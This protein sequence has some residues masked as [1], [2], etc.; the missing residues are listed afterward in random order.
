MNKTVIINMLKHLTVTLLILFS[1]KT[2]AQNTPQLVIPTLDRFSID[3]LNFIPAKKYLV[4]NGSDNNLKFWQLSDGR[5]VK[6]LEVEEVLKPVCTAVAPDG[7][8]MAFVAGFNIAWVNVD[9]FTVK[10]SEDMPQADGEAG[11]SYTTAVFSKDGKTLFVGGG[12]YNQII[13]WK[14]AVGSTK[15]VRLGSSEITAQD[16]DP[17]DGSG[18]DAVKGI[19]F[20]SLSTD[21]KMLLA[22]A[23]SRDVTVFSTETGK[24]KRI[25]EADGNCHSFLAGGGFVGSLRDGKNQASIVKMYSAEGKTL[26]NFKTTFYVLSIIPFPKSNNCILMGSSQYVVLDADSKKLGNI[27]K[28]PSKGIRTMKIDPDER[29]LAYGGAFDEHTSLAILDLKTQQTKFKLGESVFQ[30]EHIY[31][32]L[33]ASW[34]LLAKSGGG[35]LKTVKVQDGGLAVRNLPEY[36]SITS[37][38]LSPNGTQGVFGGYSNEAQFFNMQD[39]TPQ[40]K[41]I[42]G[43]DKLK[44]GFVMSNDGSLTAALTEQ[45]AIIFNTNTK[46]QLI[47]LLN[48]TDSEYNNEIF[49]GAFSPDNKRFVGTWGG[50]NAK[51]GVKCWDVATGKMIWNM[52]KVEYSHYRFSADG[53][54]IFCFNTSYKERA[55]VWIDAGNGQVVRSVKLDIPY[56]NNIPL[57]IAN[58]NSTI[59][60]KKALK[61]YDTKTGKMLGEYKPSGVINGSE[62]LAGGQ[63]GLVSYMSSADEDNLQVKLVLYDFLNQKVLANI[64]LYDETDDW[65]IITPD[66]HYDATQGAMKKMY[67]AQGT[68]LIGLEELSERFYTPKLLSQLLKGYTPSSEDNIKKLKRPPMVK[69]IYEP[70][71]KVKE[72]LLEDQVLETVSDKTPIQVTIEATAPDD[73]VEEMRLYHNGKLIANNTRNL[74]VDDDKK[75]SDK[76]VF[77]IELVEGENFLK[78]VALNSQR[79]ESKADAIKITYKPLNTGAVKPTNANDITLH[80]IVIGINKYKNPKYNLNYANADATAFKE[81]IEK[82]SSSIFSNTNVVLI[83]DDKA[84]KEGIS[85]ELDKVKLLASPKDVF[86]F[87]YAGHGVLNEKKEFFLVPHDVTQL[88]GQDEALAQKGLSANQLQQ[89]SKDIKAQKQLFILDACQSAGALDQIVA[90]RGAAEEKAIAQLARATGTHWLTA[91]GSEQF[92][93]EFAQLGHGTF[94]YVLLEALSGK[95]D[96]GGDKKVTVKELDAYLQEVVPEVTAKYKGTPQYPASYG[97][98]NDFPIG[99]VKQ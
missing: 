22:S 39:K 26:A 43:I 87:Y 30:T 5:M 84:T 98:G 42:E 93:S 16:I 3:G 55:A 36:A 48:K 8:T 2:I 67:Y 45:G 27:I 78:A 6:K 74:V 24:A 65:A 97:F 96:K 17:A 82:T 13:I 61:L 80:M 31:R 46:K 56:E 12:N 33:K 11:N 19:K 51:W 64:Y 75:E 85:K 58:D 28:L 1:F 47:K 76:K 63:Y 69:L 68:T 25:K 94:T 88:Y 91:S 90:A 49:H 20:L 71:K 35:V 40:Y 41:A 15:L 70:S 86:I 81:A 32:D 38:A 77:T 89:F 57:S 92:A 53:K 66:G 18:G 79:T 95:A 52:D 21:G 60:D 99:V 7:K 10:Q 59:L 73:V 29:D 9:N 44:N 4:S 54:E 72:L 34:F 23:G 83:S 62:L 14:V 37:A 50:L